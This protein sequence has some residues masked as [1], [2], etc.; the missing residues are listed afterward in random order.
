VVDQ[1]RR[2]ACGDRLA[3]VL[4]GA[5]PEPPHE[6]DL[7]A[8][9]ARAT[10][11]GHRKRLLAPALAVAAA[12]A[13]VAIGVPLAMHKLAAQQRFSPRRPAVPWPPAGFTAQRID[14]ISAF[15]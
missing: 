14:G 4:Y 2:P 5:V 13:A 8:I 10:L 7:S 9:R 6:L 11:R 3:G 15:A 12:E 1:G